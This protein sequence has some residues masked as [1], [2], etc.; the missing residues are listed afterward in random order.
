MHR[1]G[2]SALAGALHT[3]GADLG[4]ESS[5]VQP[6]VDNP[7]G[8]FEYAPVVDLDRDVLAALGGTWSSPP[9]M[10]Q[11]WIND[12][13]LT[14]LRD[15]AEQLSADIPEKMVVKDPRLSL[16]QPLWEDVSTVPKSIVCL[17][18]PAAVANSL[19]AR[20]GFE[21]ERGLFL[22]FR[23]SA[24]AMLN[25]PDALIVEY[26]SLLE[27]PVPQLSRV[28]HHIALDVSEKS[29]ENAATTVYQRMAHHEGEGLPDTPIGIISR[30]LY[31]LI[32]AGESLE[33]DYAAS[34]WARL[35]TELPWAGPDDREIR[36]MQHEVKELNSVL[37][38]ATQRSQHMQRRI[39]RLERELRHALTMLDIECIT[40]TVDLIEA[41]EGDRA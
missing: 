24:A 1:S 19:M 3:M 16:V 8:F 41:E 22:W 4:P 25:C 21:V 33:K 18:H 28:A 31:D 32:R 10:P 9:P 2:T 26:E 12:E 27:D 38:Q 37:D 40:E 20:N 23:Y 6:A 5:W 11:A 39:Q 15:R 17:R 14:A 35:A 36:R 29:V 30:Q 34:I 7:R 13:R